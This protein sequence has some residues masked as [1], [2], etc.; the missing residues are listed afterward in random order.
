MALR[1]AKREQGGTPK[2]TRLLTTPVVIE[3]LQKICNCDQSN[4]KNVMLWAM[5]CVEFFRTREFTVSN[6]NEF[7]LGQHLTIKDAR[8]NNSKEPR[9]VSV[10]IKQ[11]KTPLDKG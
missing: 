10:Q 8:I 5:C 9:H 7:D 6:T 3:R 4:T 11:S 2:R 1:G